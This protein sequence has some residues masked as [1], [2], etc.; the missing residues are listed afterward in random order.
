MDLSNP[1]ERKC[2][3]NVFQA[4]VQMRQRRVSSILISPGWRFHPAKPDFRNWKKV[5]LREGLWA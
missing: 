2:R 4:A 1:S 3:E 5:A